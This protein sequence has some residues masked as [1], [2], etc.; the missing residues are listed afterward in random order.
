MCRWTISLLIQANTPYSV[1]PYE[2]LIEIALPAL[3]QDLRNQ[4]ASIIE[5]ASVS[6][7]DVN[8]QDGFEL[9]KEMVAIRQLYLETLPG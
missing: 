1:E 7:E 2:I 9:Y 5:H 4:S 3:A 6:G 8:V